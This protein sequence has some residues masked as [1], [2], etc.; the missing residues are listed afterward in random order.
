MQFTP[1]ACAGSL[2]PR[3]YQPLH[4]PG[5]PPVSCRGGAHPRPAPVRAPAKARARPSSLASHP[6]QSSFTKLSDF[7]SPKW[8]SWGEK[9]RASRF[10][11]LPRG[12]RAWCPPRICD[13]INFSPRPADERRGVGEGGRV[14]GGEAARR[15]VGWGRVRAVKRRSE[16]S[17]PGFTLFQIRSKEKE[18]GKN[19]SSAFLHRSSRLPPPLA[20]VT[21]FSPLA[22]SYP[23]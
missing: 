18:R 16:V 11:H 8:V 23:I 14:R 19:F 3:P 21:G 9:A 15:G 12:S 7:L 5:Q 2:S 1:P 4:L 20:V 13:S 22:P 10:P 6:L 17:T